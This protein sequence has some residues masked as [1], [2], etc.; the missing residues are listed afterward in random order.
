[1]LVGALVGGGGTLVA[2]AGP[3]TQIWSDID[4]MLELDVDKHQTT[5]IQQNL[6]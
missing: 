4:T 1:M 6:I 5:I 2:V 3:N